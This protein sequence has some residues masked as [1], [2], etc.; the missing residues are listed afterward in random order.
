MG[1]GRGS[2]TEEVK[3]E[4]RPEESVQGYTAG[5]GNHQASKAFVVLY[6]ICPH[7]VNHGARKIIVT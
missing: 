2:F 7:L 4:L 1:A 6:F 5:W 3:F